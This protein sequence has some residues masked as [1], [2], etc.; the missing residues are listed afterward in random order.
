MLRK[1]ERMLVLCLVI[2]HD[3]LLK[4]IL[5]NITW[6]SCYIIL[7]TETIEKCERIF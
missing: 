3:F 1:M 7:E 5:R 6:K 2:K 4:N